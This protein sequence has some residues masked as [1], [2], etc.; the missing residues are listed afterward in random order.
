M[1]DVVVR[2]GVEGERTRVSVGATNLGVPLGA[3]EGE[4]TR[5]SV[6]ATNP[7]VPLGAGE[8]RIAGG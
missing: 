2:I 4:R 1:I 7:G 5:V 6:G 3:G 8:G